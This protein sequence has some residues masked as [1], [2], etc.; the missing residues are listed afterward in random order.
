MLKIN[1]SL[2]VT[3]NN[4]TEDSIDNTIII[5]SDST[6]VTVDNIIQKDDN[7]D[8]YSATI[9]KDNGKNLDVV[10]NIIITNNTKTVQFKELCLENS[11][12]L[13]NSIMFYLV[14]NNMILLTHK[15]LKA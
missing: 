13:L 5:E 12:I 4:C 3:E 8:I 14:V 2:N 9:I 15:Q 7:D 1:T 10:V 11:I 6:N